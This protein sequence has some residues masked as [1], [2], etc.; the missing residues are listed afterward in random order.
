MRI[1][2]IAALAGVTSRAVRHYHHL[3]LLPEPARRSN[4]YRQYALRDAVL[5]SRIRRL[6][7]LG[8]AL[9]EVRDVLADDAGRDLEEILRELDADLARQEAA[10]RARRERLAVLLA[11]GVGEEGPVSP[12][13]AELLRRVPPGDSPMAA[14]DREILPLL[15]HHEGAP[16]LYAALGAM[17]PMDELYARL[18][19]LADADA[20]DPRVGPLAAELAAGIP[21]ELV[22]GGTGGSEASHFADALLAGLSPAQAE[23]VRQVIARLGE[24]AAEGAS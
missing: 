23:V 9:D 20:D 22:R 2:E 12:A 18:D 1:G 4:G 14:R 21:E 16:E 7:E 5:L 13:L 3:G 11:E 10:I 19:A 15:D 8:L 24:R 17:E 6:T